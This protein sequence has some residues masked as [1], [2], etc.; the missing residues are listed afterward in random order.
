MPG[1]SKVLINT[2]EEIFAKPYSWI[3]IDLTQSCND[4]IRFRNQFDNKDGYCV[5]YVDLQKCDEGTIEG[6]KCFYV[7]HI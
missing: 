6:E 5:T 4:A 2:F 7:D 1:K 3:L